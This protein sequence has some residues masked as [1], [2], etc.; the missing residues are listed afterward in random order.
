MPW[1]LILLGVALLA[2]GVPVGAA[3]S[4]MPWRIVAYVFIVAGAVCVVVALVIGWRRR[5]RGGDAEEVT[6]PSVE[7]PPPD[8]QPHLELGRAHLPRQ[9]QYGAVERFG[10]DRPARLVQV[11]VVN[12]Q[13]AGEATAVHAE[14]I[15]MPDDRDGSFSPRESARGE[16]VE[17]G[18]R[19]TQINLPGNGQIHLLNVALVFNDGYP[20]IYEWTRRSRDARLHG[21]GM[22]SNGVEVDVIVRAAGASIPSVRRTLKI[23]VISGLIHANW[24]G[25]ERSNWVPTQDREWEES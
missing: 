15:F 9:P 8:R 19:P 20:C 4:P 7:T 10:I 21:Y 3:A 6:P 23:E 18:E 12:A 16:W 14:L 11:P 25:A 2:I 1:N 5:D 13:G 17:D 24:E 22:W